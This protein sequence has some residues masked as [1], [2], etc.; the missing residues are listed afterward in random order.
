MDQVRWDERPQLRQSVLIAAFEGWNDAGDAASSAVT[1]LRDRW[2]ARPFA[3]IEPEEFYDFT[4]TRPHVRLAGGLTREIVWPSNTFY[5]ASLQAEGRDVVLMHGHEPQLRWR[6]FCAQ[7]TDVATQL[8]VQQVVLL[9]ALLADVAHSRPVKVTGAAGDPETM[10]R[11]GLQGSRYEGPTGIVGVLNDALGKAGI[12]TVSLWATV[13]HYVGDT[14]SPKAALALV[15]RV[16]SAVDLPVVTADLA[17][18]AADY[19][20]QVSEVVAA[21]SE[22]AAYVAR[23]EEEADSAG[24]EYASGEELAAEFQRF[25]REQD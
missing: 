21:N 1:Y 2:G 17:Q 19:E 14:P 15:Q 13:P 3:E 16:A 20:G 6:T 22:V 23:L 12:P 7:V 8:D 5:A 25:L 18:L 10:A 9:G 4:S 11:L 24:L